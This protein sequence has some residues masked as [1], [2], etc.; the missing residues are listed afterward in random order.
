MGLQASL[1]NRPAVTNGV[2]IAIIVLAGAFIA[3]DVARPR[4][5]A[6]G[7]ELYFTTDDGQ[8]TFADA[9]DKL[10]PYE[11]SGKTAVRAYVYA[12]EGGKPFVAYL[13]R[14]TPETV[15]ALQK[16]DA[17]GVGP[18]DREFLVA[19]GT[20]VKKPG[21]AN[22]VKRSSDTGA[23]IVL[24]LKCPDGNGKPTLRLPT[25]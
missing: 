18:V 7:Q 16:R 11:A 20:E 17:P 3:F 1:A 22:W 24:D 25:D 15:A 4:P 2:T 13:E 12:C 9:A 5:T 14:Y 6:A 10:P 23:K 19:E 8:T 21:D